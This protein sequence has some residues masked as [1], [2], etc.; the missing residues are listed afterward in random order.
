MQAMQA[1]CKMTEETQKKL[2]AERRPLYLYSR[3]SELVSYLQFLMWKFVKKFYPV[4]DWLRLN[5]NNIEKLLLLKV[6]KAVPSVAW[7]FEERCK[8]LAAKFLFQ[9]LTAHQENFSIGK[10]AIWK[11]IK[12]N[13]KYWLG[14]MNFFFYVTF[15]FLISFYVDI[16]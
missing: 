12:K 10:R 1:L 11:Q 8:D 3:A 4:T 14:D 13:L 5:S 2:V 15:K 9:E 16:L 7:N 6:K